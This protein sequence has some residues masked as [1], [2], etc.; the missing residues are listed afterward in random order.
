MSGGSVDVAY[1]NV[2]S[3]IEAHDKGVPLRLIVPAGW[4]ERAKA[5][6]LLLVLNEGP[7]HT[8]ADLNGQ[9]VATFSLGDILAVAIRAWVDQHGG[10]SKT[11]KFVEAPVSSML[12]MLEAGR[13]SAALTI[14]PA[15]SAAL[16]TGKARLL[17]K[18][19][20]AIAPKFEEAAFA[21][22]EP[23][24]QANHDRFSSFARLMHTSEVYT[25]AHLAE[26][27]DLVASYTGV[28]PDIVAKSARAESAEYLEPR[29]LQPVIDIATKYGLISK[30]FPASDIISAIAVRP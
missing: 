12:A 6:N 5:T 18:P 24:V 23:T 7:I 3:V 19:L 13:I 10:D 27:V 2:L 14:D 4:Y 22:M 9:T 1:V 20:D 25:N 30:A 26:T 29:T 28:S 16:A 8:A 17:G 21:A 15:G 11:I